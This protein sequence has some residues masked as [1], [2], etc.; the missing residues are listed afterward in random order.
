MF[1]SFYLI[2]ILN[3]ALEF[4]KGHPSVV[5]ILI[6]GLQEGLVDPHSVFPKQT[7]LESH[8]LLAKVNTVFWFKLTETGKTIPGCLFYDSLSLESQ[9]LK[10]RKRQFVEN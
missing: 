7:N 9:M 3:L 5:L 1:G 4:R 2:W 8:K 10:N 6:N